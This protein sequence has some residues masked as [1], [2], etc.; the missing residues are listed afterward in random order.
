M[1]STTTIGVLIGGTQVQ[2]P[3]MAVAATASVPSS[4]TLTKDWWK[5]ADTMIGTYESSLS[6][7]TS[8]FNVGYH[9]AL[10]ALGWGGEKSGVQVQPPRC[11][12]PLLHDDPQV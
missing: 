6:G 3:M 5:T 10:S 2:P 8:S 11:I 7:V 1:K 9:L 12:A 4:F